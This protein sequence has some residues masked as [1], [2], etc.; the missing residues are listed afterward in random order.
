[1]YANLAWRKA[2][3]FEENLVSL[4]DDEEQ[5]GNFL[6]S[7]D[8]V[9]IKT[10]V[11]HTFFAVNGG[12]IFVL[13]K[14]LKIDHI[15]AFDEELIYFDVVNKGFAALGK[16]KD[17][18]Y[19]IK[20]FFIEKKEDA[21]LGTLKNTIKLPKIKVDTQ[22]KPKFI[23][24]DELFRYVIISFSN[25]SVYYTKSDL[26]KTRHRYEWFHVDMKQENTSSDAIT[27]IKIVIVNNN[28]LNPILYIMSKSIVLVYDIRRDSFD[29]YIDN[30]DYEMVQV[31]DFN[32]SLNSIA[33][34]SKDIV[35]KIS[36]NSNHMCASIKYDNIHKGID[37]IQIIHVG[38]SIAVLWKSS[39]SLINL[40]I[41]D[42]ECNINTYHHRQLPLKSFI[43]T[44]SGILYLVTS[45]GN[46]ISLI[47][48]TTEQKMDLLLVKN[49]FDVAIQLGEANG[50]S[51]SHV[52][53]KY[54]IYLLAKNDYDNALKHFKK[55]IGDV[56]T[57][58]V[59]K[60]YL[61]GSKLMLLREYLEHLVS[62][63]CSND[64]HITLIVNI[65]IKLQDMKWLIEF[66]K[67]QH[68]SEFNIDKG[69]FLLRKNKLFD[70]A[71]IIALE[72][73][74]YLW[75][76]Q[77]VIED[78][79]NSKL[80]VNFMIKRDIDQDTFDKI[81]KIYS[82]LLLQEVTQDFLTLIRVKRTNISDE[83]LSI[84]LANSTTVDE[85]KYDKLIQLCKEENIVSPAI[86][87]II[88]RHVIQNYDGEKYNKTDLVDLI[89]DKN[90]SQAIHY[91]QIFNIPE[92][93]GFCYGFFNYYEAKLSV[94]MENQNFPE[95]VECCRK[96]NTSSAW[97]QA[98]NYLVNAPLSDDVLN[99]GLKVIF[100]NN[101]L[102]P[103]LVMNILSKNSSKKFKAVKPYL[104]DIL[105]NYDKKIITIKNDMLEYQEQLENTIKEMD[106]LNTKIHVFDKNKCLLCDQKLTLPIISF[107]CK[108]SFHSQCVVSYSINENSCPRCDNKRELIKEPL[109]M[110]DKEFSYNILKKQINEG[111][112]IIDVLAEQIKNGLFR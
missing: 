66:F 5:I 22:V 43:F 58:F 23:T 63:K 27:G 86:K 8:I 38:K 61:E 52:H 33:F 6:C 64:D 37:K 36:V 59:I 14:K 84:I 10:L 4:S 70:A 77:I 2:A 49:M 40:T 109:P 42:T 104:V 17:G 76:A 78:Q 44:I 34:A 13:D 21:I 50:M 15:N 97:Q 80:L 26:A 46:L 20:I 60:S 57:S 35:Q 112:N 96:I 102:H 90:A 69:M 3:F 1:M 72:Y 41:Y 93:L 94:A 47:E 85:D 53:K 99:E 100:E 28:L 25:G 106:Q 31:W 108:H 87:N 98:V 74:S 7:L 9:S 30:E 111:D 24:I 82:T 11:D 68:P 48:S 103:Y 39:H 88:L 105:K 19:C 71:V 65:C 83:L 67:S 16:D 107:I 18:E 91:A 29:S 110:V 75:F 92:V 73:Q 55:A 51:L 101:G 79:K 81:L 56:E 62:C 12:V 45:D 95:I 54:A 32:P 89:D